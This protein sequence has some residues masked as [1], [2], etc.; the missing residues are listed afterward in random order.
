MYI[1]N[2]KWQAV[3]YIFIEER[4]FVCAA[5]M[6]VAENVGGVS[7]RVAGE[8]IGWDRFCVF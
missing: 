7:V 5:C 2:I 1:Y 8:G 3:D 4:C 6:L